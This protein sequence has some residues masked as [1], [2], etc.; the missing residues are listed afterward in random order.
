M[1]AKCKY[2]GTSYI[3][4]EMA[5]DTVRIKNDTEEFCIHK[6]EVKPTNKEARDLWRATITEKNS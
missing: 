5:C 2:N 1:E 6:D 3:V 4:V